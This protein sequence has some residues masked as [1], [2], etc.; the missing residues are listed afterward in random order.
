MA[1]MHEQSNS[2]APGGHLNA[3]PPP[4]RLGHPGAADPPTPVAA[5]GALHGGEQTGDSIRS[6][7][8]YFDV[9]FAKT[10][11]VV[12]WETTRACALACRHCRACAIPQRDRNE[13]STEAGKAL[14]DDLVRLGK[15]ILILT[16]G[17][18]FMRR[19]LPDLARHA[20]SRGLRIGLSPSATALATESRLAAF[21][22][23]GI[24]MIHVSLDGTRETHD[25]FRGVPGSFAR[26]I[27]I[28]RATRSL[29]L[30]LQIGTTVTRYNARELTEIAALLETLDV[31]V[32]NVFFLVPTGRGQRGDMLDAGETE[33]VLEWLY[34]LSRRVGFRVRTTAAQ[35]YRRIVVQQERRARGLSPDVPTDEVRWEATGAGYAFR[36]GRAP[37]QQGVNDGKGFAF[38]SHVGDVYPSG[39]LQI[40]VGNV[41]ETSIVDLYRDHPLMRSLRDPARLIGKCGQCPFAAICGGSRARAWA[42]TGDPLESDPSCAYEPQPAVGSPATPCR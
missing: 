3:S 37:Q 2:F 16:G 30:P 9:D 8:G 15:P 34:E 13:L 41:R 40:P 6:H 1:I 27:E 33:V 14:I 20:A 29:G 35:H 25:M 5:R 36:E 28:A 23:I 31:Q 21:S 11:Y 39:F 26:T 17:D 10:P 22:E 38:V 18:P 24:S 4:H 12:A 42:M 7:P 32:W 19:D